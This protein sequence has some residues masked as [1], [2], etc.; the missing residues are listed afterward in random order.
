MGR[1]FHRSGV[2]AGS[3]CLR[4]FL[5]SVDWR[6]RAVAP[7]RLLADADDAT[8]TALAVYLYRPW[9]HTDADPSYRELSTLFPYSRDWVGERV[10]AWKDG[11]FRDLV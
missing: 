6:Q 9:E 1:S 4:G 2:R 8:L 3:S 11:E 7:R 5:C 10:R